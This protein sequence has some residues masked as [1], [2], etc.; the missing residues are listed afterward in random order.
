MEQ[1]SFQD[2]GTIS[3]EQEGDTSTF[4]PRRNLQNHK[5][6]D[7]FHLHP[8]PAVPVLATQR[9]IRF[10]TSGLSGVIV[11]MTV[12]YVLRQ[13]LL[14]ELAYSAGISIELAIINNFFW[15][16][17]WT[18]RD[19]VQK[20]RKTR[21]VFARFLRFNIVCFSGLLLNILLTASLH[22]LFGVNVYFASLAAIIIVMVWNFRLN[23][24]F[25]WQIKATDN[26][27]CK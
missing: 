16:E 18:F 5:K 15:N 3:G 24:K 2:T 4:T 21:E 9:F 6:T 17:F 10:A 26:N 1:F 12:L 22:R 19:I 23:L 7:C 14:L 20:R 25:S 27:C 8:I 11:H 13:C